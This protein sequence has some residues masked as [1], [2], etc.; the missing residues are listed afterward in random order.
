MEDKENKLPE[1]LED[2]QDGVQENPELTD[3]STTPEDSGETSEAEPEEAPKAEVEEAPEGQAAEVAK[4]EETPAEEVVEE[5]PKEAPEPV[6][7]VTANEDTQD[8]SASEDDSHDD[9]EDHGDEDDKLLESLHFDN[10]TKDELLAA[11]KKVSGIEKMRVLDKALKEIKPPF[12]HIYEKEKEDALKNFVE[13]GNDAADFVYKGDDT[14]GQFFELYN[15]LRNKKQRFFSELE[16]SKDE[17]LRKKN[18][19]L[20]KLRELVD[21]EEST[22]SINTLKALQ[23]EWK[24]LGQVPGAHVK[25]LW[26][27]YN[28]LIDRFYDNRSIYFELKELDRRKNLEGKL[29]LCARAEELVNLENIK[30]AIVQLNELHE[31]FKHIGPIP[32]E[33]Q[34]PVWQR[35]KAASDEI[36]AKRKEF[37]DELKHDLNENA[38][39]KQALGDEA[40]EFVSFNSDKISDWNKKTKQL[41]ELQKKWEAIGGLPR[42]RAK[43]INKHFWGNFKTFFANKNAFF[44][45][46]ETQREEN[47]NKKK[48][49]LEKAEALKNSEE[50]DQTANELKKLQNAWRDIGPVPEKYRNEVYQK[51]KA[52]C[53]TFFERKRAQ[54][55]VQNKEFDQNLK[56]KEEICA[57]LEAYINADTIELGQ[58][59]D[60]LERYS[61]IGFVPRNAIKKI[62]DRYDDITNRLV[63]L[64]DLSDSQR[65][66]L[67]TQVQLSKLKNSPHGG[68]KIQRKEGA[69]KRKLSSLESDIAT[70]KTNLDFFADSK[71]A[72]KL[73]ADFNEKIEKATAEMEELKKQLQM[74]KQI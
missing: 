73:K 61:E 8:D 52:A 51:F 17:N 63:S 50:W 41:L 20:E 36:Y 38:D 54:G 13:A 62:H 6:A 28:A 74:L 3:E 44:K 47:Y 12:D 59:Y 4:T 43:H 72:D 42:D 58:V 64:E 7:E 60:L 18:E 33:D 35:F 26:A 1:N 53:D 23:E 39:K 48:E 67:E 69:I 55:S 21:G 46:L 40:A 29:E 65:S 31:E 9:D 49:L 57:M 32:K 15:Q 27:N 11:L 66:E 24:K 14:D 25:S 71:T 5:S 68:Q 16:K 30:E 37:F 10:P 34:E 70:W 45:T 2:L 22:A 56:K 19:I